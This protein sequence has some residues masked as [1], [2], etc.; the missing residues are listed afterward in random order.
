ACERDE[1]GSL[2][3]AAR[4]PDVGDAVGGRGSANLLAFLR[5]EDGEGI[6]AALQRDEC[7]RDGRMELRADVA[8]DLGEGFLGAQAGA[9]GTVA[10]HRVE[11]V[12]NDEEVRGERLVGRRDPVVAAAVVAL[13]VVLDSARLGGRYLEPPQQ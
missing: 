2:P 9:V 12:G 1:L 8:L 13:A 3:E 11:A 6:L 7:L 10:R 4:S 5:R